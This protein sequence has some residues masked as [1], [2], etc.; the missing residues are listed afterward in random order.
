MTGTGLSPAHLQLQA[1]VAA[2]R[3]VN[4]AA[5]K[6]ESWQNVLDGWNP[7]WLEWYGARS[8]IESE[9]KVL[10]PTNTLVQFKLRWVQRQIL[11]DELRSRRA[12]KRVSQII[13]KSRKPGVTTFEEALAYWELSRRPH[14]KC[15]LI[16]HKPTETEIMFQAVDRFWKGQTES[17]RHE[18][19]SAYVTELR[20]T[21]MDAH[22]LSMAA[23]GNILRGGTYTRIH[24]AECAHQTE[25]EAAYA[26]VV[27]ARGS[28]TTT[29]LEST[30]NGTD[31]TGAAFHEFWQRSVKGLTGF[32]PLFFPWFAIRHNSTSLATPD[33]IDQRLKENDHAR[34]IM[35]THHLSLPQMKWWLEKL[36]EI[37]ATGRSAT[38][39]DQEHPSSAEEAFVE[40]GDGFYDADML[41]IMARGCSDDFTSEDNGRLRIWEQPQPNTNYVL[42][43]DVAGGNGGDESAIVGVNAETGVQA[44]E[45][46]YNRMPPD[47]FGQDVVH[48]LAMRWCNTG[49]GDPA[50]VICENN[51]H[52]HAVMAT[53]FRVR[54]F[55]RERV[56][57]QTDE[58]K[59][60]DSTGQPTPSRTPGWLNNVRGHEQLTLA[61]GRLVREHHPVIK[62]KRAVA[63]IRQ[64]KS[65]PQGATFRGRDLAVGAGLAT[66]GIPYALESGGDTLMYIGGKLIRV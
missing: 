48:P 5:T 65:G 22:F 56:Y 1:R 45:Y 44:F 40:S 13:L 57:H 35:E 18:R 20:F 4:A 16:G 25:F 59:I 30:A 54:N 17:R 6:R 43:C 8:F 29:V 39:Q 11:A 12:R 38:I 51:N 15:A 33:E 63:S 42:G 31:G 32:T 52:G 21:E 24:F 27:D 61:V 55:P 34:E 3:R 41:A 66:I 64:V 14:Q 62:S 10:D 28:E 19:S 7:R 60:D 36:D 46:S 23:A 37:T 26:G 58:A 50:Y 2:M 49:S 53:L 47:L 9:L